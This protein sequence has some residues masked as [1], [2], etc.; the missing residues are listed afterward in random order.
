M[1]EKQPQTTQ[2]AA[3]AGFRALVAKPENWWP[4]ILI[5]VVGFICFI[6]FSIIQSQ[7]GGSQELLRGILMHLQDRKLRD[8]QYVEVESRSDREF[9]AEHQRQSKVMVEIKDSLDRIARAVEGRP[10]KDATK[11]EVTLTKSSSPDN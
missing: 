11:K 7:I 2:Q 10:L 1:N 8:I 9:L 3:L 4:V 6:S 5:A